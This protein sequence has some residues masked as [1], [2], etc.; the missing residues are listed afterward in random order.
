MSQENWLGTCLKFAGGAA[1]GAVTMYFMDPERGRH[2]RA[3]CL[4]K[5][6]GAANRTKEVVESTA[7]DLG[8][9]ARGVLAEAKS[10]ATKEYART[11]EQAG[12][13]L[14]AA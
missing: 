7:R 4:D 13:D 3:L 12:S 8:N 2:R 6:T 9:R 10:A 11:S 14:A 5:L 1:L